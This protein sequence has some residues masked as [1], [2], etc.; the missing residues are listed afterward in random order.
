MCPLS[1]RQIFT[2]LS[3]S[4]ALLRHPTKGKFVTPIQLLHWYGLLHHNPK[5]LKPSEEATTSSFEMS[6]VSQ[7]RIEPRSENPQACNSTKPMIRLWPCQ[8]N[9]H[10]AGCHASYIHA[11]L[12]EVYTAEQILILEE[13]A[14]VAK[15]NFLAIKRSQTNR[16]SIWSFDLGVER[17]ILYAPR[18]NVWTH[19]TV[20]DN[21]RLSER[22][23]HQEWSS[24][25]DTAVTLPDHT[26]QTNAWHRM[27]SKAMLDKCVSLPKFR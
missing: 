6:D 13:Q 20:I 5:C 11:T 14:K 16:S 27:N 4:A 17:R 8:H 18:F 21:C 26:V 22:E 7:P 24:Y 2:F 1:A 25:R 3:L 15:V 19:Q 12:S 9:T 10:A 23:L